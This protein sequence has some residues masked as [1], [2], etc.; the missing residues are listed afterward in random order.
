VGLWACALGVFGAFLFKQTGFMWWSGAALL[1]GHI[2]MAR[3][4]LRIQD[5]HPAS[6]FFVRLFGASF[7][8]LLLWL[9]VV[10][11]VGLLFMLG[12]AF[13]VISFGRVWSMITVMGAV[14]YAVMT[15]STLRFAM[16]PPPLK[17]LQRV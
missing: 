5:E 3:V 16:S 13:G 12:A 11:V 8:M 6:Q 14:L 17:D 7:L 9:A 4:A 15:L 2:A 10:L 1:L